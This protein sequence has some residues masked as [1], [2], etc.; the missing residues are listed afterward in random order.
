MNMKLKEFFAKFELTGITLSTGFAEAEIQFMTADED[1]AWALYVELITRITIQVLPEEYGV[2][3][4]ALE[5]IHSVFP[6]TRQ[7]LKEYGRKGQSFSKVAIIILNQ[8][9]RPFTAKWHRISRSDAWQDAE[10]VKQFRSEL[11]DLQKD[12]RKFSAMLAEIAKVDDI[13]EWAESI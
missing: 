5:S 2:E 6:T 13:S 7:I 4:T 11:V 8:I 9:L 3:L 12:L 10:T 1:A